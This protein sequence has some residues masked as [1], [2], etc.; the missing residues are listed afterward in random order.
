MHTD[1]Y[2][3]FNFVVEIEGLLA[4]GFSECSGLQVESEFHEYREGGVNGYVHRFWGPA[5]SPPLVL[6]RGLAQA[7]AL[8]AWYREVLQGHVTRRNGTIHLRDLRRSTV[9]SW[10]FRQAVPSKWAGPELRADANVLAF[11]SIELV[12][13]GIG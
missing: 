11:E 10:N 7:D 5:K 8:W 1:P 4:G 6:R 13:C 12:H 3:A 9:R 2:L